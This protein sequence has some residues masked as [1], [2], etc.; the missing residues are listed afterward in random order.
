M[1]FD[2]VAGLEP[3][4]LDEEAVAEL[5]VGAADDDVSEFARLHLTVPVQSA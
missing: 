2:V 3:Q 4:P 1:S 5:G